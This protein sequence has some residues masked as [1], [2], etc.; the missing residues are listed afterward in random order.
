MSAES[1]R[2]I[3]KIDTMLLAPRSVPAR[4]SDPPGHS[5]ISDSANVLAQPADRT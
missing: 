2:K 3:E 1:V 4:L 5:T